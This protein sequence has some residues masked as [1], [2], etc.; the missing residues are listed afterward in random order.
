M[1]VSRL[2]GQI[3]VTVNSE[4][5]FATGSWRMPPQAAKTIAELARDLAPMQTVHIT[6]IG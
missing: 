5:L 6:V 4:L 2:R 3:E 1:R